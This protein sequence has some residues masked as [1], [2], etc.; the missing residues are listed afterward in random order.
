MS[1]D[2]TVEL[3][4]IVVIALGDDGEIDEYKGSLDH[5]VLRCVTSVNNGLVTVLLS[6]MGYAKNGGHGV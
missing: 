3:N 5:N 1:Y 6:N 4:R 2:F